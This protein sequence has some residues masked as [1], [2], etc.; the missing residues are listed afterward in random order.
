MTAIRAVENN[1]GRL[2]FIASI[3][4]DQSI[5]ISRILRLTLVIRLNTHG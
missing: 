4:S 5:H 2:D 1:I 3:V